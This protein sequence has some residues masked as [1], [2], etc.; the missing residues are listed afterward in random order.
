MKT[1]KTFRL[2]PEA[3]GLLQA[4]ADSH[5]TTATATLE[6]AIVAYTSGEQ[7]DAAAE[8]NDL[9]A[10]VDELTRKLEAAPSA[11]EVEHLRAQ[12]E[13]LTRLL[14][15]EQNNVA[16]LTATLQSTQAVAALDRGAAPGTEIVR[17][18]GTKPTLWQR[19]RGRW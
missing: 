3:V 11:V 15:A 16:A 12:V 6:A 1:Q 7:A 9:R 5:G 2:D 19:I 18:D 8:V 10:R 4:W 17:A 13:T 14:E